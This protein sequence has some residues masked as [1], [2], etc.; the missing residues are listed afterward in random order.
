M[1]CTTQKQLRKQ[2]HQFVGFDMTKGPQS[3]VIVASTAT[4]STISSA[5]D[6]DEG[7]VTQAIIIGCKD[8]HRFNPITLEKPK[9]LIPLCNFPLIEYTLEILSKAGI[10]E[11]FL[12]CNSFADQYRTF[13]KNSRWAGQTRSMVVKLVVTA[14]NSSVGDALR[15][16]DDK[17]IIHHDFILV[18][19]DLVGNPDLSPAIEQHR[20]HR[21][22][23]KNCTLT[24]LLTRVQPFH[25]A[26]PRTECAV[27]TT[28]NMTNQLINYLPIE[29]EWNAF[30]VPLPTETFK[31]CSNI[32][33]LYDLID[34][35]LDICSPDVL[36]LFTEN[37][38]YQDVRKDFI[39]GIL[40]SEIIQNKFYCYII[41]NYYCN[42][43][44]SPYM[45]NIISQDIINRWVFPITPEIN[46]FTKVYLILYSF[47]SFKNIYLGQ[48]VIVD[49]S[50]EI[51]SN[52]IIGHGSE[53]CGKTK[54][55][56]SVIGNNVLIGSNCVI[57]NCFIWDN[58]RIE[59]YCVISKSIISEKTTLRPHSIVKNGCFIGPNCCIGPD[60][61]I[62]SS[63]RVTS[64]IEA[65][66][67][68]LDSLT[69]SS[70]REYPIDPISEK[71]WK[72]QDILGSEANCYI[73]DS[74]LS[75]VSDGD[76]E[77]LDDINCYNE[78][79]EAISLFSNYKNNF[80]SIFDEK[81]KKYLAELE[82]SDDESEQ[83]I[84]SEP[85]E[86]FT[87]KFSNDSLSP[88]T[89]KSKPVG[90]FHINVIDIIKNAVQ[91]NYTID[92][93]ALEVNALKFACNS[94]F[95]DC[96]S[97]IIPAL[98]SFI[99]PSNISQS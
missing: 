22:S 26:R 20:K 39:R 64:F 80:K 67:E 31:K 23:D 72:S 4:K 25:Y 37:F 63:A 81:Y 57:E 32:S 38:D 52:S 66:E 10:K 50:S 13:L 17:G 24:M 61:T 36:S 97:A 2:G 78:R 76:A 73:W 75:S 46:P 58:C 65:L 47:I 16:I 11:A 89:A 8:P 1:A 93:T 45:Y 30:S 44:S 95:K 29:S 49:R 21:I 34:C 15:D 70:S 84:L 59:D 35:N 27:Y 6:E 3:K 42:R 83:E 18:Y 60:V 9:A 14:E 90:V 40:N 68:S 69:I 92:N 28:S 5:T 53:I 82:Y 71:I 7:A 19:G 33:M 55:I 41:E 74:H 91:S 88:D 43:V 98:C 87:D 96:R 85:D 56:N 79:N 62:P 54:I 94:S 99:D 86:F 12:V 51:Q 48:N 77:Y